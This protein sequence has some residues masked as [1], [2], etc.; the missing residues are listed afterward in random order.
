MYKLLFSYL[1]FFFCLSLGAQERLEDVLRSSK[2]FQEIVVEAERYFQQKYPDLSPWELSSGEHKDGEFVKFMRWRSYWEKSLLPDGTLGDPTAYFIDKSKQKGLNKTESPYANVPWTNISYLGYIDDQ[3]GLGRTTS[4][5]FHPTDATTFYVGAA[6]GGLW[7]TSDGGQSYIPL[8]DELPFLAVSSVVVDQQNPST[9]YIAVS[10]HLWYGPQGIGIYKS[11]DD[12]ATWQAT[13]LNFDFGDDIRIYWIEPDPTNPQKMLVATANGIY[14][15]TN[16]FSTVTRVSTV[17]T[18]HLRFQPGNVNVVYA[19][20]RDGRVMRSTNGGNSFSEVVDFG[21]GEVYLAVT[22][23]APSKVY[24]RHG[25]TLYK[26]TNSGG[27]FTSGG[28][29]NESSEVFVFSPTND[30]VLLSGNFE[31]HRSNNGGSSFQ[32]T[33][34]WLGNN[35]LPDIHVDQRNMFVNPLESHCVYYCNDG[36][37]YRFLLA[38]NSFENLSD[39][40]AIT[41]FYDIAVS[42]S[43]AQIVSGGSQDNGNVFRENNGVWADYAGTGDGMNQEIDPLDAA[44][45]YWA[46][47]NGGI[48]RWFNGTNTNI[49]PPG[50]GSGAWETPYRLDPSNPS[51]IIIGYTQVYESTN[52]GTNWSSISGNLA[53]GS[54]LEEIAIAPSNGQRIYALRG[55]TLYVKNTTDNNWTNRA[56]PAAG[57]S[58][59][60]VDPLDMN[61]LYIT[62]SGFSNGQKVYRSTDAGASWTNISYNLPN[63]STGAIELYH[64]IAG[65]MFVGTD[66][67]VYYKDDYLNEWVEYGNLPHTR[68]EDIEIQ[69]SAGLIRIG[70]HGRGML[71]APIEVAVCGPQSADEDNDGF[72]D[73][74]DLCPGFNNNLI[75]EPCEDGDPFSSGET[76]QNSCDCAGGYANLSYCSAAG[77]AGTGADYIAQVSLN[78]F[79]HASGQTAYSDFRPIVTMEVDYGMPAE[80]MVRI[81][82]SFEPDRIHTWIDWNRNGQFEE[83]EAVPMT[84]PDANHRTYGI[85]NVPQGTL[86]GA[87]TMR[88]RCAYSTTFDDP[89][90]NVFGEVEDYNLVVRCSD[91]SGDCGLAALPL[92]WERFN[93]LALANQTA[94]L[95]WETAQEENIAFFEVERSLDGRLFET[96]GRVAARNTTSRQAYEWI[97]E[98]VAAPYAYYRI[99]AVEADGQRDYTPIRRLQWAKEDGLQVQVFP[100][101]LVGQAQLQ[102]DWVN[103]SEEVVNWYLYNTYGQEVAT[104]QSRAQV[105]DNALTI[106]LAGLHTGVHIVRM[107][108]KKWDWSARVLKQ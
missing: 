40:L 87:T 66:A 37:V 58:D 39:G 69:Y 71:E 18:F 105:G 61:K 50:H 17:A 35:G 36:G 2:H 102:L 15:T 101:P 19:G 6:I 75:G 12:G 68:V 22:P 44:Y 59:I 77:T 92:S 72:C 9:L 52:R 30:E 16:G 85:V 26:S 10:D 4:M 55:S 86:P 78:G 80:L 84:V 99:V 91:P 28:T 108:G 25:T 95:K 5:A 24:A 81:N 49:E 20:T 3:I 70:T 74:I 83:N 51:R 57:I 67:G 88:V 27:S 107:R 93:A 63:V 7:K 47:Q 79:S 13:A 98:G 42:Q 97:D 89:C 1:L 73:L 56:L 34:H 54:S 23:L 90:G 94:L 46:Y 43:D 76:Y 14:L 106:S 11:T 38:N 31:T 41:Q 103:T 48:R 8:G 64:E 60:E 45:R 65:A 82:F 29:F 100:N 32:P 53:G 96:L 104:G 33:M 21:N 62:V